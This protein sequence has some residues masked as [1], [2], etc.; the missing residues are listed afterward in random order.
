MSETLEMVEERGV[1]HS[2]ITPRMCLDEPLS[3]AYFIQV[4]IS[5]IIEMSLSAATDAMVLG[6]LSLR[7]EK[8]SSQ[9]GP[10]A[11]FGSGKRRMSKR[12]W[13]EFKI[14]QTISCSAPVGRRN[15]PPSPA[16]A[17][18]AGTTEMM[19]DEE[20]QKKLQAGKAK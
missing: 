11:H 10:E 13:V 18:A 20:R 8:R 9:V 14:S 12:R 15:R 5:F 3:H 17:A 2:S 7:T 1:R 4:Q 16:A 19:E 6:S